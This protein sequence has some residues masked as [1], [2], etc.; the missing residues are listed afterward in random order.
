MSVINL[1]EGIIYNIVEE[2]FKNDKELADSDLYIDDIAAYIL[3]RIP[4]KYTTSERGI[5]HAKLESRYII[6][7]KTDILLLL[8]EAIDV[9][10][11]RRSSELE[12]SPKGVDP[13]QCRL[14]HIFGEVLEE[15]TFS[16]ISDVRVTLQHKAKVA[17]M[18]NSGWKNSYITNKATRGFFHFWPLY[19]EK[20]M[21]SQE[22][23]PFKL[24]FEHTKFVDKEIDIELDLLDQADIGKSN[25]IPITLIK[26]KDGIDSDFLNDQ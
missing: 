10:K 3:N 16:I 21:G 25:V 20:A 15:S 11:K 14:S 18:I 2:V 26:I 24:K 5:L 4:P 13:S 1:K 6:Q 22:K 19:D 8:F 9:I 12:E 7:Q 23:I 17:A